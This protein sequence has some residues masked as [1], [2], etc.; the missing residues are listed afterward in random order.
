MLEKPGVELSDISRGYSLYVDDITFVSNPRKALDLE[1][2]QR[3]FR[4][5]GTF[6]AQL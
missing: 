2:G 5:W 3:N 6:G 1:S 4:C